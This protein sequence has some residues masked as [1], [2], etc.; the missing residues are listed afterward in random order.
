[1]VILGY[2]FWS[3]YVLDDPQ[4][5]WKCFQMKFQVQFDGFIKKASLYLHFEPRWMPLPFLDLCPYMVILGY[6]FL[7]KN[8]S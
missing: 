3:K 2:Y 1:M 4:V 8:T 6:Y 5:L 7:V